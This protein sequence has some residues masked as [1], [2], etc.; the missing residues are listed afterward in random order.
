MVRSAQREKLG[1]HCRRILKI[2][3]MRRL[4][5]CNDSEVTFS[6]F[7]IIILTYE[8]KVIDSNH[9]NI[10]SL[11]YFNTLD[12]LGLH[13]SRNRMSKNESDTKRFSEAEGESRFEVHTQLY[14]GSRFSFV[15]S[16]ATYLKEENQRTMQNGIHHCTSLHRPYMMH[17]FDIAFIHFRRQLKFKKRAGKRS[18]NRGDE[19]KLHSDEFPTRVRRRK[20]TK[21]GGVLP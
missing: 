19:S 15:K 14:R 7:R 13:L 6:D 18:V 4:P 17:D 1:N 12:R 9:K 21:D 2:L 20:E 10:T 5:H 3:H 8:S 16:S 11:C